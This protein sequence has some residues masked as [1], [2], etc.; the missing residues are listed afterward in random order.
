MGV[1]V[2]GLICVGADVSRNSDTKSGQTPF[3][4]VSSSPSLSPSRSAFDDK[5]QLSADHHNFDAHE[6]V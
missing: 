1:C 2:Y 5:M 4:F 3:L 6:H